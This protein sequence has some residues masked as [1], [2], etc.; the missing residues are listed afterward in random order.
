[1]GA[2]NDWYQAIVRF[3]KM[4]S[5]GSNKAV[6]WDR[7]VDHGDIGPMPPRLYDSDVVLLPRCRYSWEQMNDYELGGAWI[8]WT[9]SWVPSP[10][11][12]PARQ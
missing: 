4:L 3:H 8:R 1:M 9:H 6:A 12:E 11:R 7:D 10:G 5:S 2:L